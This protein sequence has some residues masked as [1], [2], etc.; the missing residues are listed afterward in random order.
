VVTKPATSLFDEIVGAFG[1][2]QVNVNDLPKGDPRVEIGKLCEGLFTGGV[3]VLRSIIDNDRIRSIARVV[4]DLVG[5]KRVLVAIGPDVPSLTFTV[6]RYKGLDQGLVL[7]PK[8][9]PTMVEDDPFM[10]LGAILFVGA[11]VVDFYNDRLVGDSG[12]QRRWQAYEAE[13][14]RTLKQTLPRWEPN[15]YQQEIL[16]RYPDGIDSPGVDLYP[17]KPYDPA[18][19]TA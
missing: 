8:G 15:A 16:D 18:Q 17:Y 13:L 1:G 3:D 7:I 14:L 11:Q 6:M 12:A 2:T 4:W 5:H 9:W 10:Q 19:G